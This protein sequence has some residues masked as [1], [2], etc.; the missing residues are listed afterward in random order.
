[1][2][3]YERPGSAASAIQVQDRYE[4]FIGG[5]WVAPVGGRYFEDY[6]PITGRPFTRIAR[7]TASSA[8]AAA[9][10]AQL[11]PLA[12]LAWAQAERAGA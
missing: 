5:E 12:D 1:M 10:A 11:E 6:A 8:H 4:H 9:M 3:V 2:T 7:G